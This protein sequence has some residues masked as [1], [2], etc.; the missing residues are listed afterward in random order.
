M[1]DGKLPVI[2]DNELL[3]KKLVDYREVIRKIREL[4][5]GET[6]IIADDLADYGNNEDQ[7]IIQEKIIDPLNIKVQNELIVL[8]KQLQQ[9]SKEINQLPKKDNSY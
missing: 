5:G 4:T 9:L 1:I 3:N 6:A 8:Q 2:N 7:R